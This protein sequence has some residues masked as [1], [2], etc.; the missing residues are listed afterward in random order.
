MSH[1]IKLLGLA[2]IAVILFVPPEFIGGVD[3]RGRPLLLLLWLCSCKQD[4]TFLVKV[5]V[6]A[7]KNSMNQSGMR[8]PLAEKYQ[9]T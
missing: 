2:N 9:L 3:E 6:L 4:K 7:Y 8:L 1:W 5:E